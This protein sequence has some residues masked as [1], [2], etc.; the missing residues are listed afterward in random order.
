MATGA[1]NAEIAA[2]L[3]LAEGIVKNHVLA[4]LGKLEQRDRTGPALLLTDP[5]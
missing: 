5:R 4:L 3:H 1:T 2:G